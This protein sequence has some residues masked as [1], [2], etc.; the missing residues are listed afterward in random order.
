ME[1]M[2]QHYWEEGREKCKPFSH[3]GIFVS[4]VSIN[5]K[6]FPWG[7]SDCFLQLV[8]AHSHHR[9]LLLKFYIALM[10]IS[11]LGDTAEPLRMNAHFQPG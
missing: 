2:I 7:S 11:V 5:V 10:P 3:N 4:V 6:K 8:S 1:N 9:F